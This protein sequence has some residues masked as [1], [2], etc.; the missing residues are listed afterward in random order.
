V[1]LVG[2]RHAPASAVDVAA[3]HITTITCLVQDVQLGKHLKGGARRWQCVCV[4]GGSGLCQG[5]LQE[6]P[7]SHSGDN[8]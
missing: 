7:R 4:G 6:L 5:V 2:L 3:G 1:P 8:V